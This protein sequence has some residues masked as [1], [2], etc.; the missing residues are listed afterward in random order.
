VN[1][2]WL[3]LLAGILGVGFLLGRIYG[4]R[5]ALVATIAI[6]VFVAWF[7]LRYYNK[8]SK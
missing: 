1:F 8:R 5:V 6:A 3:L 7:S 4:L 2:K